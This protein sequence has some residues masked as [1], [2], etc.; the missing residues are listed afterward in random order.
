MRHTMPSL[1]P[2]PGGIDDAFASLGSAYYH[3]RESPVQ[4]IR[5]RVLSVDFEEDGSSEG[6]PPPERQN[7]EPGPM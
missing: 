3:G 2:Q 7:M 5:R 4:A 1:P 6:S